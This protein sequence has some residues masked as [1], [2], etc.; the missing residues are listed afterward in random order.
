ML[1]ISENHLQHFEK[2]IHGFCG[3][4]TQLGREKPG[5]MLKVSRY[6]E[7]V[8]KEVLIVLF[9]PSGH[10]VYHSFRRLGS[11]FLARLQ[12]KCRYVV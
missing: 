12:E 11:T 8:R 6:M 7:R 9:S 10:V 3:M 4:Y 2:C 1:L 5:V